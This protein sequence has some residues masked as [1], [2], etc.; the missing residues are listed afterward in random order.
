MVEERRQDSS[1]E[2][3]RLIMKMPFPIP[4]SQ[5]LQPDIKEGQLLKTALSLP[6]LIALPSS[7]P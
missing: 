3:P 4:L 5:F 7:L 6:L 1:F 2:Q